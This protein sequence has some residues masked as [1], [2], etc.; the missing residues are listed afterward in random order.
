ML[1]SNTNPLGLATKG[2]TQEMEETAFKIYREPKKSMYKNVSLPHTT[3][4][5]RGV[6]LAAQY[7][8]QGHKYQQKRIAIGLSEIK[9]WSYVQ[10]RVT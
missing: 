1:R 5:S 7:T 2:G 3:F 10:H 4:F 6:A 9:H 8:L